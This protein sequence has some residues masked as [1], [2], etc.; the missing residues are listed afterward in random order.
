MFLFYGGICLLVLLRVILTPSP[1][2]LPDGAHVHARVRLTT[3]PKIVSN[4]QQL[5][6]MIKGQPVTLLTSQFVDYSYG[7]LLVIDGSLKRKVLDN[8]KSVYSIYFPQITKASSDLALPYLAAGFVRTRV[9]NSFSSYLNSDQASLLEGIV[10]GINTSVDPKLKQAFQVTGVT[11]VIAASGM[12]VT[13]LAGFL[14]PVLLRLFRR[15]TSLLVLIGLLAFYTLL[16][17]MSASIIRATLMASI[18][19][20]GLLLGRQRTAFIS[21]FLTGCIMILITPTILLDIGFQLSFAA[22]AGMLVIRPLLPSLASIPLLKLVEEDLTATIAAQITTLPILIYYFH[23]LGLLSLI[24]NTLVLWTVAPLMII[25]S[26]AALGGLVSVTLGGVIALMCLPLL[27]YFLEV[28]RLFA[29]FTPVVTIT[30]LP[31]T[32][33]AG[34]YLVVVAF[35]RFFSRRRRG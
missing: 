19:F 15:R 21:F 12:N 17:G 26:L 18:G 6:V 4:R 22:T 24:V 3:T 7:D 20:I 5:D 2:D 23:S 35:Y 33:V 32:I 25:G 10:F 31:L 14:L 8:G 28:I 9:E 1:P 30:D 16:S 34:Y 13:L 11:H 27:S 29:S